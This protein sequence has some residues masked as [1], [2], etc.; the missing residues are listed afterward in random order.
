MIAENGWVH[1][2]KG[3]GA[4]P[5]AGYTISM[6][7]AIVLPKDVFEKAERFAIRGG[8]KPTLFRCFTQICGATFTG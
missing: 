3:L 5:D 7:T 1:N 4:P 8:Q 6:K 2:E